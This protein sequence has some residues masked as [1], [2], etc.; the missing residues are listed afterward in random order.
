MA[1][2]FTVAAVTA[3]GSG[4]WESTLS[5]AEVRAL[6]TASAGL[7]D[8]SVIL[9]KAPD[10][11]EDD[12]TLHFSTRDVH[13]LNVGRGHRVL[14]INA[15][16]DLPLIVGLGEPQITFGQASLSGAGDSAFLAT[17]HDVPERVREAGAKILASVREQ[18]PG[19]LRPLPNRRFQ[20]TPDNFWF[21][22]VQPRDE[23]LL[24]IVRGTPQQFKTRRLKVLADRRSY[25][26]FKVRGP[27]DVN[28][29]VSILAAADRKRR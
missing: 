3:L 1:L 5:P 20:E 6:G 12:S 10:Y 17:L 25:C 14:F 21:V 7:G 8:V 24:F 16:D 28:E 29:A 2:K 22:A 15:A 23:S 9:L 26:R 18:F 4:I 13:V 11:D 27:A 19:D